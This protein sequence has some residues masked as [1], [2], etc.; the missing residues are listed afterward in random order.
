MSLFKLHTMVIYLL[1]QEL[2]DQ[3]MK[4]AAEGDVRTLEDILKKNPNY[5]AVRF[6]F[7]VVS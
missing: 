7:D 2:V 1:L 3:M 4:A 5:I 6:A